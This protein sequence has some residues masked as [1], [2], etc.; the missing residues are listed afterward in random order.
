M[1]TGARPGSVTGR[2]SRPRTRTMSPSARTS[3][4]PGTG[5]AEGPGGAWRGGVGFDRHATGVV[6]VG[7]R[8]LGKR[9]GEPGGGHA[10]GPDDGPR[11]NAPRRSVCLLD[12]DAVLADVDDGASEHG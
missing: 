12:R 4:R 11:R 10:G 8:D 7:V 2:P 1:A 3:G 6:L 5:R 9:G